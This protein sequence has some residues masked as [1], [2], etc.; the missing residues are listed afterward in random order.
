MEK[1]DKVFMRIVLHYLFA[2]LILS[3]YGSEACPILESLPSGMLGASTTLAFSAVF[4]I[5]FYLLNIFVEKVA[6]IEQARKQFFYEYALMLLIGILVIIINNLFLSVPLQNGIVFLIGFIC[7]GFFISI[8]MSLEKERNVIKTILKSSDDVKILK[9]FYPLTHKFFIVA[10]VTNIFVMIIIMVIIGDLAWLSSINHD[11]MNIMMSMTTKIIFK[12]ISF[13]I[14]ILL[15]SVINVLY[16]VFWK[17]S[18]T[19][20]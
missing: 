10:F 12:E 3:F 18:K 6:L 13:V 4:I 17:I 5:R 16:P 14:A 15:L 9:Q 19:T 8:D 11:Q 2:A 20:W 7:F 1:G